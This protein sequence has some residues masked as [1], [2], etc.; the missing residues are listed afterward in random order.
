ME[1]NTWDDTIEDIDDST[2]DPELTDIENQ[3]WYDNGDQNEVLANGYT[4]EMNNAYEFAFRAGITTMKSI[5]E[6][7]MEWSLTRIAMAKMLSQYAINVLGKT[8]DTNKKCEFGDV[9]AELD[10][11][12]NSWVTLACQLGI[13]WVGITD[14]RPNDDV[15]RTEFGTALSRLLFWLTDGTDH[16]Y[17][18][19]LAKLKAEWIIQNDDP[20]LEELRWYVM[21]MLRRS[22]K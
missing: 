14:F 7:N 20:K 4:R 3:D 21:L 1:S 11:Q 8:P 2:I 15:I 18:T 6:A 13:M 19:H 12:Y 10:A 9:S 5:Q 22:A 17:T 16:Y